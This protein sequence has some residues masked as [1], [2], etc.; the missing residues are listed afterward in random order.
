MAAD[1]SNIILLAGAGALGIL[2]FSKGEKK[3]TAPAFPS[4]APAKTTPTEFIH[5]YYSLAVASE[6]STGVPALV[7]LAQAGLESNWGKN[8]FGNNFFGIKAGSSWNGLTQELKT[9]ECSKTSDTLIQVF[10]PNTPGSNPSCN[11]RNKKSYRVYGKFRAYPTA[12]DGFIDHGRFLKDNKRYAAAFQYKNS[13]SQF[14][15]EISKSGYATAPNYAEILVKT[16]MDI[17]KVMG[18]STTTW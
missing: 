13:P 3:V 12:K 11:S 17:K 2:L 6:Y 5:K 14:A 18:A 9:W 8:A 1:N 16:I 10:E 4:S 15:V 7:T